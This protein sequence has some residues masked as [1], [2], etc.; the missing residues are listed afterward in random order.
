MHSVAFW[1][2][3]TPSIEQ[4]ADAAR[5]FNALGSLLP[6]MACRLHY[7]EILRTMPVEDAVGDRMTLLKWTID[8]HNAVNLSTGAKVLS[9]EDAIVAIER[10]QSTSSKERPTLQYAGVLVLFGV[11]LGMA[12]A[13]TVTAAATRRRACD[14][15]QLLRKDP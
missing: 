4:Q 8:V 12:L 11:V 6:C 13:G 10:S 3:T 5:F 14:A 1:Y 9:V 2:P 7:I 15:P